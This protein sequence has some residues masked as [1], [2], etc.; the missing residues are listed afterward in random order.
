MYK[1]SI[2]QRVKS[3]K[4]AANG[5]AILFREEHNA[6]IHL[7]MSICVVIAG[8]CFHITHMEWIAIVMSIGFVI[9][10]E[11]LNSAIESLADFVCPERHDMIK[12]VKDLSAA[13][14]LLAAIS[15]LVVG[16]IVF[17]SRLMQLI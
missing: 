15:A 4:H 7:L 8:Y 16:V 2:I 17:S 1:F 13:S 14:V 9:G 12:K 11:A 3:F 6:R 10:M 5:L